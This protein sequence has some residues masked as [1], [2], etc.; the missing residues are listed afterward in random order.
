MHDLHALST[1]SAVYVALSLALYV[2]IFFAFM[3]YPINLKLAYVRA[4][5]RDLI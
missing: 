1:K 5:G 2:Y 3:F 4:S